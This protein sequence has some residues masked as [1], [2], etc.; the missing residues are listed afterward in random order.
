MMTPPARPEPRPPGHRQDR[1]RLTWS[2]RAGRIRSLQT[3]IITKTKISAG[4]GEAKA[5]EH[6]TFARSGRGRRIPI[7]T[8]GTSRRADRRSGSGIA[9]SLRAR[10]L[11]LTRPRRV[12]LDA[13]HASAAHPSAA[14][15]YRQ[16]RRHLPRV[17]L[18][19][20]YRN[21]RVLAAEGLLRERSDASGLRFDGNTTPHDHFTCVRCGRVYDVPAG[22]AAGVRARLAATTGFEVLD[23]RIEFSGRCAGCRQRARRARSTRGARMTRGSLTTHR[24]AVTRQRRSHGRAKP[25]EQ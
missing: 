24:S 8:S 3:R 1:D 5:P 7:S 16:V 15:V 6:G 23:H 4:A 14:A 13:V 22:A 21:L 2:A 18:A 25:Q 12:I 9:E 10:G 20:V 11:R 17:S 19:T